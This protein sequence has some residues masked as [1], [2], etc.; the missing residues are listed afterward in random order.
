VQTPYRDRL[1]D[2]TGDGASRQRHVVVLG[3]HRSGTSAV[4]RV[5]NLLGIPTT[6]ANDL[7]PADDGNQAGYW[8]SRRVVEFNDQLL[9]RAWGSWATPPLE[10][11]LAPLSSDAA[12]I[13]SA[14]D[15][16]S[17]IDGLAPC[18][19]KDPRFCLLLPFWRAVLP[20]DP[21]L[22]IVNRNPV[23]V[24]RSLS[25]RHALSVDYGIA[26]WEHYTARLLAGANGSR[27]F[28]IDFDSALE[29]PGWISLLHR[30]LVEFGA[31]ARENAPSFNE[32]ER[33]LNRGYRHH[34]ASL[35]DLD[36]YCLP[37]QV[38][39]HAFVSGLLGP[40]AEL[41]AA[42]LPA[43]SSWGGE[44]LST[45]RGLFVANARLGEADR[46]RQEIERLHRE[47]EDRGEEV[48]VLERE[49]VRLTSQLHRMKD[50]LAQASRSAEEA[51]Q[52]VEETRLRASRDVDAAMAT[53]EAAREAVEIIRASTSWKISA[54]IRVLAPLRRAMGI[55][56]SRGNLVLGAVD[57]LR[58]E[59]VA[60]TV[61]RARSEFRAAPH[62]HAD[63]AAWVDRFDTLAVRDRVA[64]EKAVQAMDD[65]PLISVVM[66]VYNSDPRF[67]ERAVE[68]VRQQL[69]PYWQ[70]CL[71]DDAS[72]R[73]DTAALLNKLADQD[74]RI[75]LLR[76]TENGGIAEATNTGL[77][78]AD[79]EFV[80]FID[81]DDELAVTALYVVADAIQRSS[82]VDV[83]YSDEDKIDEEGRR[84][85]PYFKPDYN[86]ELLL[87]QNYFNHLTIVRKSLLDEVGGVRL[88]LEGSQDHDLVLRL[89]EHTS[90]GRIRHLPF[91]LYHWRQFGGATSFSRKYGERAALAG[92]RAVQEHL[93]R[94]GQRA[95]ATVD[96][97]TPGWQRVRWDIP[98]KAPGVT[99]VIPTR[100]RL[101]LLRSCVEGLL[102]ATDY[103]NLHV[104]VV[105]NDSV[106][107]ATL[108]YLDSLRTGPRTSVL[109]VG[110]EFNYSAINNQ[111][112]ADVT[113]PLT[114][115]L[116][117]DIEVESSDWLREM[118][119]L[120][121]RDG[122]G[123]V[124]AKLYYANGT[125]Q[126]AGVVVGIG[127]VAGHAHKYRPAHETGYFGRL[128]LTQ[129][130][131]AVTGAC[132][133]TPTALWRKLGG[134]NEYN[135]AI[136]FNDVDYC[137]RL[138]EAGY[139]V[140]WA[141]NAELR[142]LESVSRGKEESARQV[143][144]F[145]RE[146]AWMKRRW[147]SALTSDPSYNP[148]LTLVHEDYSL[149]YPPRVQIP[150]E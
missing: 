92:T 111:A 119:G 23:E 99:A 77:A 126:H 116:N 124:G 40:H 17:E 16:L 74:N 96:A 28:V 138:R 52:L 121:S 134:L 101:P 47:L 114:L 135:L 3:M 7:L 141:A 21:L 109:H 42:G 6:R 145:N 147:G 87:A 95:R 37:S 25:A 90:S 43:G 128:V 39:L 149:A 12:L 97:R 122:V 1:K 38:K 10:G 113:T 41:N 140:L 32:I 85:Q 72:T 62:E 49:N 4:T 5:I 60:E 2:G 107:P 31:A 117:N 118:V 98:E 120:I 84:Y 125:V 46:Q 19:L 15:L 73:S 57:H 64:I 89:V 11:D 65:A 142:H 82:D 44:L 63:Y 33:S 79:G 13:A 22:V 78:A 106:E 59:G 123:A 129:E 127:G 58:R 70:L 150:W 68:S 112:V 56:R 105:D 9:S 81:H 24:A 76:R 100:D 103:E 115:L 133:L 50:A 14:R 102:S 67:L 146:S 93:E 130:V 104:L 88:D 110:G 91:V 53:A 54:P 108:E 66:P 83:L 48:V 51:Q 94:T 8:E 55:R 148:N 80:A 137:L 34:D 30:F 18:V 45:R 29:D 27:A 131:S 86:Y 75:Q 69:Y 143:A 144:R 136:A 26:L 132:L 36:T 35:S 20:A 71:V 61:R 139:R